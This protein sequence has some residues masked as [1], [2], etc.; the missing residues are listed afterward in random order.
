MRKTQFEAV[1]DSGVRSDFGTGSVRDTRDGKGRYDLLSPKAL[2][3][4][5]RHM[6]NGCRKYGERNW[7]KGQPIM[8]YFDSAIRHLYSHIDGD[9]SE[10]HLAAVM[11]NI[12]CAIHTEECIEEGSLSE[13]LDD[14]PNMPGPD[15]DYGGGQLLLE[16]RDAG[17]ESDA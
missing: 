6:E 5:A 12:H 1:K 15:P 8:R 16:Y 9:R 10:D 13:D 2:R 14:R 3:R 11:W 4:L 7:E 17:D